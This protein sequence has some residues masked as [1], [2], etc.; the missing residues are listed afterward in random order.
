MKK[1]V[2]NRKNSVKA[3]SLETYINERYPL[4]ADREGIRRHLI[5]L[6]LEIGYKIHQVRRERKLTQSD[7]A[8]KVNTT[9]SVIARIETGDQ[10]LTTD[11]LNQIARA[12]GKKL[13]VELK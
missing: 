13:E 8:K 3:K 11:T 12:L 9:Q 6:R 2:G 4:R 5:K 1:P 7:L 10:N